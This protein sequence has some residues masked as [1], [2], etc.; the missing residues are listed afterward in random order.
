MVQAPSP[1]SNDRATCFTQR[2]I[3]A[4]L[5]A[6]ALPA[7]LA[8]SAAAAPP[9]SPP[10]ALSSPSLFVDN[11]DV[12]VS[13]DGRALATWRWSG[14]RPASGSAPGGTR[15]AVRDA[16]ALLFGPERSAPNF[17]TPLVASGLDRVVGLDTRARGSGRI[18]LRARFGNS[19]GE[20]GPPRTI[21]T[22]SDTGFPPSLAGPNGSLVAWI[23]KSA[24]GRRIVRAALE[25]R[26]RFRHPFTLRSRGRAN[27]VVA[28]EALG[29]MFVAWERAGRVEAR[30]KLSSQRR[31]GPLQ[32]LGK[33][34]PFATSFK[35]VGSGRRAYLAWLAESAESA[36]LQVSVLPAASARFRA[37]QALET[38]ARSA[39]AET[40]PFALVAMPDR[41]ALLAWTGWDGTSW[42]V[43]AAITRSGPRFGNLFG[44]TSAGQQSVLGDAASVPPGTALPAGTTMF[45]WSRLDAVGEVGDRV[46]AAILPPGGPL[47]RTED[48]SDLDRARLPAVAFDFKSVR[49]TAV[50]SQRA[51]PDAPGVP[52]AQVTTFARASTRPG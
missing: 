49:W 42:R 38:I 3:R 15:L 30:V 4:V 39:P 47:G 21:S 9:W 17:V 44:I 23:A 5:V 41:D 43:R 6:L 1:A 19:Q 14:P 11:P 40:H 26:G 35:V 29:V 25:S 24:H 13:A 36:S 22:Y 48:V 10:Q 52:L 8:A 2:M 31:W 37:P 7:A 18:S 20:F 46:Q 27:D 50:W 51:G 28:G 33:A 34:R 32:R 12:V 45:V 16:G